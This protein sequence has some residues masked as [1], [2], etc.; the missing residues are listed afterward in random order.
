MIRYTTAWSLR[1]KYLFVLS[2]FDPDEPLATFTKFYPI[3][4]YANQYMDNPIQVVEG[5][6]A[7][8]YV[9]GIGGVLQSPFHIHSTIFKV[10]QS[11][12]L[13][14]EPHWAQ[15]HLIGNGDTAI[16]EAKWEEAGK[17]PIPRSRNTGGTRFH[18]NN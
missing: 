5:E 2:E 12:I 17:V 4:G 18:G 6:T 7:R 9:M 8:F 14:N 11:G 3:N 13:W 15:T 16:I 10:W 1:G